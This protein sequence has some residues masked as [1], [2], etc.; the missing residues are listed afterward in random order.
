M[1]DNLNDTPSNMKIK[2]ITRNTY[3]E[4][5]EV[6]TIAHHPDTSTWWVI[7][8]DTSTYLQNG[9]YEHEI[10]L[11]ELLEFYSYRHL[12]NCAFAPNTY[13]LEQMLDRLFYIGKQNDITVTYPSFLDEDRQ[14][15][16]MSFENYT[17]ANAI[18]NISRTINAIPKVQAS[19]T[20]GEIGVYIEGF[21][22]TF[23]NRSGNETPIVNNLDQ[24]FAVA[25]EKNANSSDQFTTRSV[26]NIGNA[27]SSTLVVAP[28]SGGF[29]NISPNSLTYVVETAKVVLPSKIDKIEFLRIYLPMDLIFYTSS[30]VPTYLYSGYYLDRTTWRNAIIGTSFGGYS[31]SERATMADNL[32]DPLDYALV[33]NTGTINP[34]YNPYTSDGG[35]SR[36]FQNKMIVKSKFDFDTQ[37]V[38]ATKDR[39]AYWTPLTEDLIMPLSFR[40]GLDGDINN[41]TSLNPT[42]HNSN[43][44][45][46]QDS[47]QPLQR[48]VLRPRYNITT[49]LPFPSQSVENDKIFIQVGY[50]PIAD[51]KV[52]YDN[53]NE[54]QDEKFFNQSG[55]IIDSFST[56]QLIISH[57]ND[58]VEG[59]KI[60][61]ARYTSYSSILPLGQIVRDNNQLYIVAQRSIDM[62]FANGNNYFNVVYTLSRNRIARSENI[63]ADSAVIN[64]QIPE[65]NLVNRTQLYK[66]YIELSLTSSNNDTPYL[67]MGKALTFGSTLVGSNFDYTIIAK[68][69]YGDLITLP[70]LSTEPETMLYY[71]QNP[72]IFDLAKAKLFNVNWKDNNVLGFRLDSSAGS[73]VQTPVLYTDNLGKA[74]N[75]ELLVLDN[76][77]L[78]NA[79]ADY[80]SPT[81]IDP[82]V[83]FSDLT[84][85]PETFYKEDVLA[86][87]RYSIRIQEQNYDKDPFEIPVFEY[88][89]QANDNYDQKG[90]VIVGNDL[91]T[92][93]TKTSITFNYVVSE[94]RFTAEN[95]DKLF[96]TSSPTPS[97]S[98]QRVIITRTNDTTI[99]LK[100]FSTLVSVIPPITLNSTALQ[101]K[102]IGFYALGSDSTR[103]FL[104]AINDYS[105]ES[106][107]DI[108]LYINNWKI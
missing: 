66:D 41:Y 29:K 39:T 71:V 97:S 86:D 23:V 10:E 84:Q 64:Y 31:P 12:P 6:N 69:G 72:T 3:R 88:M 62:M 4:E 22:L 103:K 78:T 40:N 59:T 11:V 96:T 21:T 17:I 50:Y 91:F 14:M 24:Q 7:K 105:M 53:N 67:S 87:G 57:T 48:V 98:V 45:V 94:T 55:K 38:T 99:N 95:A 34:S 5:F 61:N 1:E 35:R 63:Q 13:S 106:N 43:Y 102:H 49:S 73:Y 92:S 56:T 101:G 60:R 65:D 74:T 76:A 16:F 36:L 108:N 28:K 26:S 58:S 51:I 90:N 37:S 27:K 18:K 75:F 70:D 79:V 104:F 68:S 2:T 32:P 47:G 77:N 8:A 107:N 42:D 44:L 30:G 89:I 82:V 9:E 83:P 80:N 33:P 15:P 20:A 93:Y 54:A 100:L 19:I 81:V 85:V 46:F 52:S 25:Y